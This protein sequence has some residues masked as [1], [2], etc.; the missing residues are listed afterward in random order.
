MRCAVRGSS[1]HYRRTLSRFRQDGS[2][3]PPPPSASSRRMRRPAI[4]FAP[5]ASCARASRLCAGS[6]PHALTWCPAGWCEQSHG[7]RHHAGGSSVG[8]N[9]PGP[10]G[11]SM[12]RGTRTRGAPGRS[13]PGRA[14]CR[15]PGQLGR[16]RRPRRRVV[17]AVH[18]GMFSRSGVAS[19]APARAFQLHGATSATSSAL[20]PTP[21]TCARGAPASSRVRRAIRARARGHASA[22][23]SATRA[24]WSVRR[25]ATPV[26]TRAETSAR[27]LHI[28]PDAPQVRGA[29][30]ATPPGRATRRTPS[31]QRCRI[32]AR[33][34]STTG[35]ASRRRFL[36]RRLRSQAV[37][38]ETA[39]ALQVRS[40]RPQRVVEAGLDRAQPDVEQV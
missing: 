10:A 29:L 12:P 11:L 3:T 24:A 30:P 27:H 6:P 4:G 20:A 18:A 35:G 28:D 33:G 32:P 8:V 22:G 13:G 25:T 15:H 39:I 1:G 38:P 9:T 34:S 37:R 26:S 31:E 5:R 36:R 2:E 19:D 14:R 23:G 7:A 17:T 21:A 16:S 40:Q